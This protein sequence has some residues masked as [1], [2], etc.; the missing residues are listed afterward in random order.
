MHIKKTV[1][2]KGTP[3]SEEKPELQ[4]RKSN[5]LN[6]KLELIKI[7]RYTHTHTNIQTQ[8]HYVLT[9]RGEKQ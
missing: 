3:K 4:K 8:Q 2:L 9:H 1:T 7:S 6:E 5:L